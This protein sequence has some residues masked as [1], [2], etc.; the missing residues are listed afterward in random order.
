MRQAVKKCIYIEEVI[1]D[2]EMPFKDQLLKALL[3]CSLLMNCEDV[4]GL[5]GVLSFVFLV[6][7]SCVISAVSFIEETLPQNIFPLESMCFHGFRLPS[8][9]RLPSAT[10]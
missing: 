8:S 9:I 7:L 6:W 5:L 4:C 2:T 10:S 1:V 3:L